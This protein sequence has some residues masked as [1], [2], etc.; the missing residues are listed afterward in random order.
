MGRGFE[1]TGEIWELKSEIFKKES[2]QRAIIP[3]PKFHQ[4]YMK[5]IKTSAFNIG[6]SLRAAGYFEIS[7]QNK[8]FAIYDY[9]INDVDSIII[10]CYD[11][12][13]SVEFENFITSIIYCF[14]LISGSLIRDELIILQFKKSNFKTKLLL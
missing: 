3:F 11:N 2:I 12:I 5:F 7:V 1:S 9:E 6:E 8:L 4:K 10:D 13:E 14:A